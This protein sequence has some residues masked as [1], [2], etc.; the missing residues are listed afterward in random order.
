ML[1]KMIPKEEAAMGRKIISQLAARD[2]AS[3]EG[4]LSASLR[5]PD[6]RG[7]LEEIARQIPTV[8][9][10][11]I[12]TVGSHMNTMNS[13]TTYALT[14]EYQYRDTWL[15][16][17]TV[18][19]RRDNSVTL[20]G[21]HVVPRNQSLE[22]ENG[23]SLA[24]KSALHY[25]VVALAIAIPLFVVYALVACIRTKVPRRKWLWLLFVA[26]GIVQFHFN[27]TTGAWSI[28]P[29]AFSLLGAGFFKSGPVAPYVF[30]L[31][32]PLGALVFLAKRRTLAPADDA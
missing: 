3:V 11:A 1:E 31:A 9:P 13:V 20:Q 25:I 29:L 7:K 18:L 32:F 30:I 12:R 26:M 19:E 21:V 5:T 22:S 17:S 10:V 23:F 8:E 4:Q 2:Y 28:Q 24:D 6:I 16:A 14:F 27:W 15:I